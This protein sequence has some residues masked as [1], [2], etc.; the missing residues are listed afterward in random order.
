MENI[1]FYLKVQNNKNKLR[2]KI[3][4][5]EGKKG[6]WIRGFWEWQRMFSPIMN[7]GIE[8]DSGKTGP[9]VTWTEAKTPLIFHK[10]LLGLL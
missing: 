9:K 5:K 10:P 7:S 6:V 1:P 3:N 8:V 4:I 2:K